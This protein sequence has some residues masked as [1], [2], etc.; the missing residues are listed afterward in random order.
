MKMKHKWFDTVIRYVLMGLIAGFASTGCDDLEDKDAAPGQSG[1]GIEDYGT[2]EMYILSEGLFNLNNSSLGRY[3]FGSG[4]LTYDYF[5]NCNRR[6]LGDTA[7]DMEIYDGKLYVVVNVSSVI[8]II[9]LQT[10]QS[11]RQLSLVDEKGS[12]RQP[13]AIAFYEDHAYV[14]SFDGTVTRIHTGSLEIDGEIRAGRNPEDLCVQDGKL[15]V[16]NSGGLD[17]EGIGVDRTV[18]II[19]LATFREIKRLEVGPNPGPVLPGPDHSVWLVTRGEQIEEGNYQLVKIDSRQDEVTARYNEPVM[20]FAIDYNLAYLY[21]FDYRTQQS[22]F[23]VFNLTTGKVIR[24]TFISD[25]T[26]I[27]RPYSIQVNP[28][29]SNIYITEAYNYQ[30]E[31]DLLC[32]SPE[33]K[34]QFR[35]DGVGLNPNTV[36]FRD[37]TSDV[38]GG[39]EEPEAPEGFA[40]KVLDYYPAPTQHMNTITT[41]WKEGMTSREEVIELA[42]ERLRKRSLLS[43]GAFGGYIIVGFPEPVPNVKGEYDFKIYGN[44]YYNPNA[45]EDRP[46]GSSEPG[47]VWVS[48]D[49]NRNGLPDDEWYELAGSEYGKDTEIRNYEITYYRPEPLDGDVRWTDN[50]GASGSLRRNIFHLQESYYPLWETRGQM[51]FSGTRL[52]DNA[53]N[54]NG[55]WVSYAYPWGYADNHPNQSEFSQFKIDWAVGKDGQPVMLEEIDFVKVVSAI[56]Q[57]AGDVGELSTEITG[58]E[59]LHY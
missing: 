4:Q 52:K 30:L 39:T 47:I 55:T 36:V 5:R 56:N 48:Q 38:S 25:G 41:A 3:V 6:G 11:V 26:R 19:D 22:G 20:D 40:D 18:S 58:V 33:G 15:Y 2:A 27:E 7:N 1:T 50:Q 54:E 28:Y 14:C 13:R 34:L 35:L 31:G 37:E 12:S 16:T 21:N 59:N 9:D 29:S 8:E 42:T 43:L 46:G 24:E 49:T 23:K 32:F 53:V 44:A 45:W 10:G 51:T 17:S 57:D